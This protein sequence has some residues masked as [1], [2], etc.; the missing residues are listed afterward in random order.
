MKL[1]RTP[2]DP[3][4]GEQVQLVARLSEKV[5]GG[6]G[7]SNAPLENAVVVAQVTTADGA[8]VADEISA[9]AEGE[10]VYRLAY[11][12]QNTGNYKIILNVTTEDKRNF[13]TD[14][15]VSVSNAPVNWTFWLGLLVLSLLSLGAIGATFFAARRGENSD[16]KMRRAIPLVFAALLFF[17]VG[18][19]MLAYFAP[20]RTRREITVTTTTTA[21]EVETATGNTKTTLTINKES[22]LLFG[23]RTEPVTIRQIISGLKTTGT[24]RV[25]PDAKAVV[26]AQ[27]PGRIT[28]NPSVALGGAVGRGEQVGTIEQVLD[29]SG[30]TELESQRLEVE[31]QQREVEARRLELRNTVLSLQSQQAEQRSQANQS[32]TRLAQAQ[33]EL[34]R[35][36]NLL[37]V[38]AVPRKRV[39]EAQ[40]AVKVAEQEVASSEQQVKLIG[41]QIRSAQ[42]GMAQFTSPRANKPLRNFPLTAP[43]SGIIN[44]IK[45]TSGQQVESG[46]E[47]LNIVNL[48]TVLIEAQIFENDL[49][50]VRES[51]RAS[52][53]SAALSGEVY[54][55]GE[56]DGD[57]RIVSIGQTLNAETRTVPVIYEV[58][59][60]LG[61]LRD[62]MFVEITIDTSGNQ[63]VLAVPKKAV[64]SE[65]GETFVFVFAGGETFEKRLIALGAEGADFYEVKSGLKE[66]ERVVTEGV[67][68]L[69][70]T[71][72]A[73]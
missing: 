53:T 38:G 14:F 10:G 30:Q 43:V 36:V 8:N 26:T 22:Q 50:L 68:Q 73:S 27:V 48:S 55:I 61:R 2:S 49:P 35:S 24:V 40:T 72:P 56:A 29:V 23:I 25:R 39:E 32:R 62:G 41:E 16:Q 69:R 33:R 5:E 71:Q 70:T 6:F 31:A 11:A 20:P 63:K 37:E 7:D 15:P 12:F 58:K 66:N 60:S 47:L 42:K 1:T 17:A 46:A 51:T 34:R 44:E 3:R 19:A 64:V 67:Y 52:F 57:G 4:A 18:T 65:N 45:V 59:N 13:S 9:K 28:F 21:P 54:K